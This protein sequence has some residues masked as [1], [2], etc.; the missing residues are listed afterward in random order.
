MS[1]GGVPQSGIISPVISNFVLDGLE[2]CIYGSI[3]VIAN[4]KARRAQF[5]CSSGKLVWEDLKLVFV[6]FADAIVILGCSKHI[7]RKYVKPALVMFLGERGLGISAQKTSIF[8]L[9]EKN[10]K[11]LGH[12]FIYRDK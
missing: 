6:R 10:L 11:Y 3:L 12:E 4:S 5:L 7:I 2:R 9:K 8:S 1:G